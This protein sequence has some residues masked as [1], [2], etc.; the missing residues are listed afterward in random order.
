MHYESDRS[1]LTSAAIS[2]A[3]NDAMRSMSSSGT[4]SEEWE[5]NGAFFDFVGLEL[6]NERRDEPSARGIERVMRFPTGKIQHDLTAQDVRRDLVRDRLRGVGYS[7]ADRAPS[8]AQDASRTIVLRG[9]ILVH[10]R[11]VAP[12]RSILPLVR[13]FV[14]DF[15]LSFRS[16][17][18]GESWDSRFEL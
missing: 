1:D 11:D 8:A 10:G 5:A 15:A 9:E 16:F 18:S 12:H 13:H 3:R 2:F 6:A 7:F 17:C 4:G 14:V